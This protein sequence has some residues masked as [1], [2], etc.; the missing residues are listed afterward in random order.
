MVQLVVEDRYFRPTVTGKTPEN[1]VAG[2]LPLDA[3]SDVAEFDE[4]GDAEQ[5]RKHA[6]REKELEDELE[7]LMNEQNEQGIHKVSA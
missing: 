4:A 6:E 1:K 5:M 2:A 7:G 3:L